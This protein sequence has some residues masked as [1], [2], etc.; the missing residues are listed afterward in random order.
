M[1]VVD[2]HGRELPCGE[3][4]E[5]VIRGHNVMKGHPNRRIIEIIHQV[6]QLD[7]KKRPNIAALIDW[8]RT[9]PLLVAGDID[10]AAFTETMSVIVKHR[11]D[12]DTVAV[13]VGVTWSKRMPPRLKTK[14]IYG[15]IRKHPPGS[16]YGRAG[17]GLRGRRATGW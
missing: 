2:E 16:L 6:C 17:P 14:A 8:A 15:G 9:V 3:V 11:T 4:G 5:I 10:H 7:L 13:S 12:L 1:K